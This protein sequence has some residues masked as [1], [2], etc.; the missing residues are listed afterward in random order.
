[1]AV[2][3]IGIIEAIGAVG[4]VEAIGAIETFLSDIPGANFDANFE[5]S[6]LDAVDAWTLD[7]SS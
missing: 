1:M 6:T 2:G 3:A 7:A 5:T 4:I